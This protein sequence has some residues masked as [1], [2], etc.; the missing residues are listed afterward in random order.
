MRRAS[1]LAFELLERADAWFALFEVYKDTDYWCR[2]RSFERA[3]I[4]Q[5]AVANGSRP[6][7]TW[8][9]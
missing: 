9:P 4:Y 3:A 5:L 6:A 2:A 7:P 8:V 1:A